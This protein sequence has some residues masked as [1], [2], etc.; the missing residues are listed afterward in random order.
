[1]YCHMKKSSISL[2]VV[3]CAFLLLV[4]PHISA[5]EYQHTIEFNKKQNTGFLDSVKEKIIDVGSFKE[6]IGLLS[7]VLSIIFL[8]LS[9]VITI[10]GWE[11]LSWT[12][13]LGVLLLVVSG[14]GAVMSIFLLLL[15]CVLCPEMGF[16]KLILPF[17][18]LL[19]PVFIPDFIWLLSTIDWDDVLPKKIIG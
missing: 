2:G 17:I 13:G 1:M 12:I 7:F 15:A 5:I 8:V 6:A 14:I 19:S 16:H 18:M 11:T 3:L 4:M 9:D 10:L